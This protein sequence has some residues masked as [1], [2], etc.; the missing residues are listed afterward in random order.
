MIPL[1]PMA[2][3][4]ANAATAWPMWIALNQTDV[5]YVWTYLASLAHPRALALYCVWIISLVVAVPDSKA[6]MRTVKDIYRFRYLVKE[7]PPAATR[8]GPPPPKKPAR[9]KK[10]PASA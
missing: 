3:G 1:I 6:R 5:S 4:I 2:D 9:K 8:S 10:I 7:P